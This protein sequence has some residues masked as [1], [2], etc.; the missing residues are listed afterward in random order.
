MAVRFSRH[1]LTRLA[2]RGTSEQ[3]MRETLEKG[4]PDRA[5]GNREAKTMIVPFGRRW[6]ARTYEQKKIRVIYKNEPPDTVVI[7]VY[8]YYGSW[9]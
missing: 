4:L 2:A 8:V 7:T 5:H 6:G 1:V 9:P 3:E